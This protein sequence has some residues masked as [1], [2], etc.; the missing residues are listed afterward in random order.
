MAANLGLKTLG[1]VECAAPGDT[2]AAVRNKPAVKA[3]RNFVVQQVVNNSVPEFSGPDFPRLWPGDNKTNGP[4]WG[5]C[6]ALQFIKERP[7]VVFQA[8]FKG[9]SAR[10]I[11]LCSPA[12]KIGLNQAGE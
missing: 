6:S 12:V 2:G 10:A 11:A 8:F 1:P 9:Q 4:A 3:I 5:V 7:K